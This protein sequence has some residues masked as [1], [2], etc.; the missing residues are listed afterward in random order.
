MR[1]LVVM[2]LGIVLT[3]IALAAP[4]GAIETSRP[5]FTVPWLGPPG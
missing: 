1:R 4:A 3:A 2:M 5:G